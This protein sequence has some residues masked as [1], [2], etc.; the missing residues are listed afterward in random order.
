MEFVDGVN[1]RQAMQTAKLSLQQALRI[2]PPICEA[3][4]Y[5]HDRGIVHRDIKPENLLIDRNGNI[6]IVDF[7]I[8]RIIHRDQSEITRSATGKEASEPNESSETS[9]IGTPRYMAPEQ[10]TNPTNVDHRAD[11]YAL[12]V[13][14]YEM[15][16]G[17]PPAKQIELPSAKVDI[18]IRL[19]SI[20]L[21]ALQFKPSLRYSTAT[22]FKQSIITI[23]RMD[24]DST[25]K[26]EL[27]PDSSKSLLATSG[28]QATTD[29]KPPRT[30]RERFI[31]VELESMK[32]F[33]TQVLLWRATQWVELDDKR[34]SL[35]GSSSSLGSDL[36]ASI[37]IDSIK[38]LAVG[39]LPAT[40]NP[41]GL[42]YLRIDANRVAGQVPESYCLVP[43]SIRFGLPAT[44][45]QETLRW[46]NEILERCSPEQKSHLKPEFDTSLST[47]AWKLFLVILLIF[48][49]GAI[50]FFVTQFHRGIHVPLLI[51]ALPMSCIVLPFFFFT[52]IR[53]KWLADQ[54]W[55]CEP[56][57]N[58]GNMEKSNWLHS[59]Y[60]FRYLLL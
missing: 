34:L 5:A 29:S 52:S 16:T 49:T 15:L 28:D 56:W 38:R 36:P 27:E 41:L 46:C 35:F 54:L 30:L 21:K 60:G 44:F 3:L 17:E 22:D 9:V 24:S 47:D 37:P 50:P 39:I 11:I 43:Y 8:A 4:Q 53:H 57:K 42:Y 33:W 58:F 45:N 14:L 48:A 18:D 40:V 20:V 59:E 26:D 1:L 12:G 25:G 19:D 2:I 31:V 7:G 13:V 32:S 6:K 51:F 23:T 55:R 10:F